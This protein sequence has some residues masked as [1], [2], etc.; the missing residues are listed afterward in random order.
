MAED[1]QY[2][3]LDEDLKGT[4]SEIPFI[5]F[6]SMR[7][8]FHSFKCLSTNSSV[9]LIHRL[10]HQLLSKITQLHSVHCLVNPPTLQLFYPYRFF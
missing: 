8:F 5:D 6:N 10:P 2:I 9:I 4:E 3:D 7:Y 1:F